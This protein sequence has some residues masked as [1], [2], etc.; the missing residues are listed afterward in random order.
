MFN[1]LK[2]YEPICAFCCRYEQAHFTVALSGKTSFWW[3]GLRAHGGPTGGVDYVWDNGLPLTYTHWDKEQPGMVRT[4]MYMLDV[5]A[6]WKL[7]RPFV[8][9]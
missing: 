7:Q 1:I 9:R 6:V 4:G 8:S 2:P 3:I 5:S